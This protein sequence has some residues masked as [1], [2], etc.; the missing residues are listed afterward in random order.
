M[1]S[2]AP[3]SAHHTVSLLLYMAI[4]LGCAQVI[5]RDTE[6]RAVDKN[7]VEAVVLDCAIFIVVSI[8]LTL[9]LH[10]FLITLVGVIASVK[11]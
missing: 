6:C 2:D 7:L 4:L 3:E 5:A 1:S 9:I 10:C 8:V 11:G